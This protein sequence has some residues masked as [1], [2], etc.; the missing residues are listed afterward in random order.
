MTNLLEKLVDNLINNFNYNIL[1][2]IFSIK[3]GDKWTEYIERLDQY[4]DNLFNTI[5]KLGELRLKDNIDVGVYAISVSQE[6]TERTSK[7]KQFELGKKI[8]KDYPD[9]GFFVFYDKNSNFRFS[10]IYSIYTGIKR[11]FSSYKRYTYYVP[12][13]K[14]YRTFKKA[15]IDAKFDTL[16]NI[17]SAF[18]TYP[19]TKN[20]YTE[21]QNWYAWAL[22]YAQFPGGLAEENLI[23]LLTRLIFV[24]FLK[25]KNLIPEEIFDT[26]FLS[27]IIRDLNKSSNYYNA[28]LQNLFFA[29]LNKNPKDRKFANQGDFLHQRSE[30]GVKSLF[31]YQDKILIPQE[32]FIKIFEKVPFINGGLFE[33]LDE[34]SN[35]IDG[36]TRNPQKRAILPDFLFFGDEKKESLSN[37]YSSKKLEPVRGLI[38]ILKDYNFTA[39]ENSP[40]DIEVSLDPELLGHIF[41]NL[42]ACYNRETSTTAR[43]VT[44]SY[45]TPKEI[46]DFM[47]EE[48]LIEYLK[49]KTQ[50]DEDK[51]RWL[52]SYAEESDPK[53]KIKFSDEDR[54]NLINAIDSLKIL[55][56]AV[57]SGAFPMGVLHKLVH[58]LSKFDP[59]NE[60]WQN[61]Q[62]QKAINEVE[63]ILKIQDQ[64]KQDKLLQEINDNFDESI[65]YPDYA[66]KLYLIENSI[67]GVDIQ[68]IAIQICKLRFF[69]S[70]L[71][72]QKV[73]FDK[74]NCG[75]KPLPHLETKFVSANTLIGLKKP[76]IN[77]VRQRNLIELGEIAKLKNEL[78]EL[79][80]KHFRIK[81]RTEKKTL[82]NKAQTIRQKIKT[83]LIKNQWGED[84]A[85]KIA[86]FDIF[87]QTATA[88]WFDSEWM[89]G[90]ED[91]FDIVIG[92]P[93][94]GAKINNIKNEIQ[95]IYKFYEKRKNS[96]SLFIELAS[97]LLK[98][99]GITCF[100]IPKSFTFVN[101][102]AKTR[103]FILFHNRLLFIVD[104]SKAFEKVK[105]EQIILAYQKT[106]AKVNNHYK[107]KT[108]DYWYGEIRLISYSDTDLA[109]KLDLIPIYINK[110]K[111][112]IFTK[113]R[114]D[115]V[116][117]SEISK[118]YRGLP[119]QRKI[120]TN[121]G[122]PILR[123]DNIGKYIIYG[124]IPKVYL[125]E[126]DLTNKKL[127]SLKQKKIISQNIVAHVMNPFD[128]III[129]STLDNSGYITLDTVMN[130]FITQSSFSYLYI[131][132]I[133]NSQLAAWFYYWF[134]Y[135][136][137]IRT[138]H[139]DKYYMGK[140]PIKIAT[141]QNSQIIKQIEKV[142]DQILHLK[143]THGC[144]FDTY[145][146][147]TQVDQLVYKLYDLTQEEIEII[148]KNINN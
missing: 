52:F 93:P 29:T 56:P 37:F 139:F 134:V 48:S 3:A 131:L 75:I 78:K 136:R 47:V 112:H 45:Y 69:L 98:K 10:F 120:I 97:K 55:D 135:N 99:E 118:T 114:K 5:Y 28:V 30:F 129:M 115:T 19:L 46:V 27:T 54:E 127:M 24:W 39:D 63:E 90:L 40:I 142:V 66:R 9:A 57:G 88:D 147:E 89:F 6:L 53:K 84:S 67:Y 35:Y 100:V 21:I 117:L 96:A 20:F 61:L 119:Y 60:L 25:E 103:E 92:N 76:G 64:E 125:S 105:L 108:G 31:R 38:N 51:L 77:G 36:F 145:I 73:D 123:G 83:L 109:K 121:G 1:Q 34:D 18:S 4:E 102:W 81:T 138:M 14:V 140:L 107:F 80:K 12:H 124:E 41:E 26:Q 95:H 62:Y 91:G 43:K 113:I 146:L 85:Q 111:L 126:R 144:S 71:I 101:S 122:I 17:I 74:E 23:R 50:I 128:R 82:Q 130:T 104:V 141:P 94:H 70:L 87:N 11:N 68:S 137:A 33:C 110:N 116:L 2:N 7:K 65:N 86:S 59:K 13:G 79:Y 148:E 132:G 32:E 106:T 8:L 15:I 143:Q 44:G 42:L 16:E 133:L 49:T 58:I 72:D 22:K